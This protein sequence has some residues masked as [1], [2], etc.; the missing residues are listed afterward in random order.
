MNLLHAVSR[1]LT[2]K[3]VTLDNARE[4]ATL[5]HSDHINSFHAIERP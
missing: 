1:T 2:T 4:T 5:R 3:P